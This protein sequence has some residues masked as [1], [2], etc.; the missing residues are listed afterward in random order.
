MAEVERRHA[1]YDWGPMNTDALGKTYLIVAG[2]C[3]LVLALGITGL[4]YYRQLHFIRIR[5]LT[6][7]IS[8][9]CAL[10][11]YLIIVFLVYP[12]NG[13]FPCS[14]GFWVMNTYLPFGVALFQAQNMQLLSLS[15]LQKQLVLQPSN[16]MSK[17]S[18]ARRSFAGYKARWLE[19]SLLHKTYFF[20]SIGIV[21]QVCCA[22]RL[23]PMV[24]SWLIIFLT[25]HAW[26]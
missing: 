14:L 7:M 1:G 2:L 15:V 24:C 11:V 4:L 9:V 8:S 3:T 19:L 20:V 23:M 18:R 6:L 10:H 17:S 5:N 12:L 25:S 22:E 21:M 26:C 13:S 16:L